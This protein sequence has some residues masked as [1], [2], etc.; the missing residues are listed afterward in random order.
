MSERDLTLITGGSAGI[1]LAL[2]RRLVRPDGDLLLVARGP[3]RLA[4]AGRELGCETLVADLAS[5][6]GITALAERLSDWRRIGLVVNNAGGPFRAPLIEHD[7]DEAAR[8]ID[9]LYL[10]M[11]RV[12]AV[13]WPG[14]LAA[15]GS[16]V[17]VVSV[18]GT[19]ATGSAPHYAAAKHAAIA[20]SRGL[21]VEAAAVGVHV[22]T[23]NPGPV[24]TSAFPH[25]RLRQ[26]RWLRHAV[27]DEDRC[28]ASI[29][30]ALERRRSESFQPEW[31]RVA[32]IAQAIAPGTVA[33]LARRSRERFG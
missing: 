13:A 33:R 26:H 17:N 28:A 4:A 7:S 23:A 5:A 20:W 2:A 12:T 27:I 8:A 16:V 29:L 19:V 25:D 21:H 15:G 32:G 9:L 6:D 11:V 3:K 10:A 1:G 31:W 14:L 18:A 22:L 24:A 30:H